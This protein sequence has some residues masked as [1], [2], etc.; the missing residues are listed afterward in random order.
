MAL[1]RYYPVAFPDLYP[2]PNQQFFSYPDPYPDATSCIYGT[3]TPTPTVGG[4]VGA[5]SGWS[6]RGFLKISSTLRIIFY[7][8]NL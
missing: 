8:L 6:S 2:D 5:E 4:G 3:P 1:K 7:L